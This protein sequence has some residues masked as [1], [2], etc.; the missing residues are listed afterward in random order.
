MAPWVLSVASVVFLSFTGT[1]LVMLAYVVI[2][3]LFIEPA[4]RDQAERDYLRRMDAM[5]HR[6][7]VD[8]IARITAD[9]SP[10][11]WRY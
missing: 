10:Y 9:K 5:S 7:Y 3:N 6:E 4:K 1:I 11:G 2:N 8:T